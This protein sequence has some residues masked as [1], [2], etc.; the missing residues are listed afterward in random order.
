MRGPTLKFHMEPQAKG[1]FGAC[2]AILKPAEE[3][4]RVVVPEDGY[5]ER[6]SPGVPFP[7][8]MVVLCRSLL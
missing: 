2:S 6:H 8:V 5:F 3:Q 4:K 7:D 1:A